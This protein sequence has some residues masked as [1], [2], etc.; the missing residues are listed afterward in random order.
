MASFS[1]KKGYFLNTCKNTQ[2]SAAVRKRCILTF[3][4]IHVE[5]YHF[6]LFKYTKDQNFHGAAILKMHRSF[7]CFSNLT[8]FWKL[9]VGQLINSTIIFKG[10]YKLSL[11]LLGILK[12]GFCVL[13]FL[14][15]SHFKFCTK[16][17]DFYRYC[18]EKNKLQVFYLIINDA[19]IQVILGF[20]W[21]LQQAFWTKMWS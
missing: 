2:A 17:N 4:L 5:K 1:T 10:N 6:C 16:Q 9:N 12:Q 11:L 21:K 19:R 3:L 8:A 20:N 15:Y 18:Y 14:Q 13:S 7:L